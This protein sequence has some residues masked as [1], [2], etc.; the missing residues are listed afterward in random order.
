MRH[1]LEKETLTLYLEGELN[2]ANAEEVEKEID[3][4]TKNNTF[5]N[6][7]IDMEKLRYMSSAGIRIIIRTKQQNDSLKIVNVPKDVH[8]IFEMVGLLG[9]LDIR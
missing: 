8:D 4:L 2:S 3:S 7:V 6:L 9:L 5:S 1:I